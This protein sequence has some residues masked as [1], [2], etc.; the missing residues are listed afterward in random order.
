VIGGL[1][2]VKVENFNQAMMNCAT[3][4]VHERASPYRLVR[5]ALRTDPL[6]AVR[7]AMHILGRVLARPGLILGGLR[8]VYA[9]MKR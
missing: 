1:K 2:G 9:R 4:F 8:L 3:M 6:M 5:V 7:V